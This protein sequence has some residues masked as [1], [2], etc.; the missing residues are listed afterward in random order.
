MGLKHIGEIAAL[1]TA[2]CWALNGIA[3]EAAG[4]KVGSLAVNY[5][6]LPIAFFLLS[7]YSFF[8]G[9]WLFLLML[10]AALGFGCLYQVS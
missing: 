1:I 4:K 6:R 9:A 5:I 8:Q 7:V 10:P 2:I 3:F